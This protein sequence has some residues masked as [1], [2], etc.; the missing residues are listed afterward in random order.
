M[1]EW[2]MVIITAVYVVAT[3]VICVFNGKAAK[4]AI[5]QTDTAKQQIDE[6]IRQFNESNRPNVIVR[7]EIVRS[8]LLCFVIENIGSVAAEDVR[9]T[10][11]EEFLK[12]LETVDEQ[13]NLRKAT[14]ATIFLSRHQKLHI[15]LGGQMQFD[16]IAKVI[17]KF[18]ITYNGTFKE[19]TEI[20]LSQY[21]FMLVYRSEMEDISQQLKKIREEE[22]NYHHNHLKVFSEKGPLNVLVHS[23]DDGKKF[24]IYKAVCLNPGSTTE[25][26]AEIVDVSIE[27]TFDILNELDRIDKF[28]KVGSYNDDYKEKWYRCN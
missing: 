1:T 9:I 12:N 13:K 28:V 15:V 14:E 5:I 26:I 21:S 25:E 17:A 20:D 22:K 16:I 3:I 18:D 23:Y 27:D 11:N 6:M 10:V 4:A 24:E 7:F 8:G 2:I 19:H